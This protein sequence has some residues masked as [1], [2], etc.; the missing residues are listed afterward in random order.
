MIVIIAKKKGGNE[1]DEIH[2]SFLYLLK[3]EINNYWLWNGLKK[4]F[5]LVYYI[6]FYGYVK[7]FESPFESLN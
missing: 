7:K 6:S 3:K 2:Y 5:Q 1:F 4:I